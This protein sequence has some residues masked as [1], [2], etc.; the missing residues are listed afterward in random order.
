MERHV[1]THD[2]MEGPLTPR[3]REKKVYVCSF[4]QKEC[5]NKFDLR[6]HEA[7]HTGD[8][9]L[10]CEVCGSSFA[11]PSRLKQH[12]KRHKSYLCTQS[13]CDFS[14]TKWSLLRKHLSLHKQSCQFC[15]KSFSS[16]EALVNHEVK[17]SKG[18]QCPRC[19]LTYS[20]KSNLK[21]HVRTVHDKVFFTCS[22]EG[23]QKEFAHRKSLRH[24]QK[25]HDQTTSSPSTKEK[26]RVWRKTVAFA[27]VMS[28]FEASDEVRIEILEEDKD[29]RRELLSQTVN[30]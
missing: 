13:D 10:L 18:L 26:P 15:S 16:K 25:S 8:K 7:V 21:T 4:C 29:F 17:H 20:R 28:G 27:E 24:H 2:S 30:A 9:P 11:L 12:C 22:F 5:K 6:V 19:P 14:A 3:V 1:R 23:C